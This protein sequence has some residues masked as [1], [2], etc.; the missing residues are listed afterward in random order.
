[1]VD[2]EQLIRKRGFLC[3]CCKK[4]RATEL[5]HCLIRRMKG[6][7]ELDVE[8]NLTCVCTACHQGGGVNGYLFRQRFWLIQCQ[9]YSEL[10]MLEWLHGLPLRVKPR[11]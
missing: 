9:R 6:H 4:A 10:H 5:H 8:E 3:E 7:P 1:M 2:K 11:F